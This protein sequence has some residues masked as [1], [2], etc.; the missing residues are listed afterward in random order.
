MLR[1]HISTSPQVNGLIQM[2]KIG[3]E[4]GIWVNIKP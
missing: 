1:L 2:G 4:E 3:D